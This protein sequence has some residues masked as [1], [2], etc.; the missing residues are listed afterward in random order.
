MPAHDE[1]LAGLATMSPT[2]LRHR[3]EEVFGGGAPVAFG[4]DLLVRS[5]AYRLQEKAFG[6]LPSKAEREIRRM[7]EMLNKGMAPSLP[8][9]RPGTR[10]ARDWHGRTHHVL[11]TDQGF[12]YR[13]RDY[14]SLTA[15]ACEITGARWSGPRFFGLQQKGRGDAAAG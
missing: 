14:R 9:L 3:W 2:Q 7:A 8:R 1:E 10:L 15:I 11:V 6:R 12:R 4:P 13:E 5:I